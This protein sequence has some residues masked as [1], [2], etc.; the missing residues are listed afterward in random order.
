MKVKQ[1]TIN[2]QCISNPW[3]PFN[4]SLYVPYFLNLHG[5]ETLEQSDHPEK[6]DDRK[7]NEHH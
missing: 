6:I 5:L 4:D 7:N 3:F 2:Y 1:L